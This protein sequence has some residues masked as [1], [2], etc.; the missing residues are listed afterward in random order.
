MPGKHSG[1]NEII[2]RKI[3]IINKLYNILYRDSKHGN[4]P[5]SR[6]YPEKTGRVRIP[7]KIAK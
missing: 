5:V 1:Y 2:F 6:I 4:L 7:L 3:L